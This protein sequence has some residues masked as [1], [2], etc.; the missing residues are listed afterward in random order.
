M[1]V[2]DLV[3]RK[4]CAG[5]RIGWLA[6]VIKMDRRSDGYTYPTFV[7]VDR[8]QEGPESCSATLLEVISEGR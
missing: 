5:T 2:G 8:P 7:Y 1:K 6:V 3:R 4:R